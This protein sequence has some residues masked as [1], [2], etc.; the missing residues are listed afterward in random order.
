MVQILVLCIIIIRSLFHSL[1]K[2]FITLDSIYLHCFWY[3][4]SCTLCLFV[5]HVNDS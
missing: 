1:L 3:R 5:A 4:L 2:C